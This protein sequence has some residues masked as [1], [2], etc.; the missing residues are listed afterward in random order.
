MGGAL[1]S[2]QNLQRQGRRSRKLC[3]FLALQRAEGTGAVADVL[4]NSGAGRQQQVLCVLFEKV[5]RFF[6]DC[7]VKGG[8]AFALHLLAVQATL[9]ASAARQLRT[10]T[11]HLGTDRVRDVDFACPA[12]LLG[13]SRRVMKDCVTSVCQALPHNGIFADLVPEL[14]AR[15]GKVTSLR[16]MSGAVT[17][18]HGREMHAAPSLESCWTGHLHAPLVDHRG[19]H[20]VLGRIG[21]RYMNAKHQQSTNLYIAD[22]TTQL[23]ANRVTA[24]PKTIIMYPST[25]LGLAVRQLEDLLADVKRMTFEE[26]HWQPWERPDEEKLRAHLGRAFEASFVLDGCRLRPYFTDAVSDFLEFARQEK[27]RGSPARRKL[28]Y[29]GVGL[30]TTTEA[31]AK[32]WSAGRLGTLMQDVFVAIGARPRLADGRFDEYL[33]FLA[34]VK[35][36]LTAL[37]VIYGPLRTLPTP[38]LPPEVSAPVVSAPVVAPPASMSTE[39]MLAESVHIV[40]H[41]CITYAALR[42][43][44]GAVKP[45]R[46]SYQRQ[47]TARFSDNRGGYLVDLL[48]GANLQEIDLRRCTQLSWR[49]IARLL[50]N[51]AGLTVRLGEAVVGGAP[52][53][54]D[55][56][57]PAAIWALAG[58]RGVHLASTSEAI[59]LPA[60]EGTLWRVYFSPAEVLERH[61]VR[62]AF[63]ETTLDIAPHRLCALAGAMNTMSDIFSLWTEPIAS[64]V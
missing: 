49:Q 5:H 48:D 30:P 42:S 3:H 4:F 59:G 18:Y 50:Q 37:D 64:S 11:K 60:G 27:E 13:D 51:H 44:L 2:P 7:Y 41:S 57:I 36:A 61:R 26:T 45:A 56:D 19:D 9:S 24:A 40:N 63:N 25:G 17:S 31:A 23:D 58:Q 15:V 29:L 33:D 38:H 39:G 46:I 10:L 34:I 14:R 55:A 20:H 62:M 16:H 53:C 1:G 12:P 43:F 28:A 6:P 52:I 35:G 21:L 47:R 54:K 22:L 32:W 8:A